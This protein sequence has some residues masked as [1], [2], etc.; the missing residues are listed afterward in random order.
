M[1]GAAELPALSHS[2]LL[3]RSS[4][5][6]QHLLLRQRSL[7][8]LRGTKPSRAHRASSVGP[9]LTPKASCWFLSSPLLQALH[10]SLHDEHRKG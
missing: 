6:F 1:R 7:A 4:S 8:Q 2:Q 5:A 10:Q 9:K 3:P